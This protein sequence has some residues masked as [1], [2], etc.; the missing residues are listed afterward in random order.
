MIIIGSAIRG[1]IQSNNVCKAL[2]SWSFPRVG[3]FAAL[4]ADIFYARRVPAHGACS[5]YYFR[6]PGTSKMAASGSNFGISLR[7]Q[8]P[9]NARCWRPP[10]RD[11]AQ[12]ELTTSTR[13][14]YSQ[15]DWRLGSNTQHRSANA[16][17]L[18]ISDSSLIARSQAWWPI[19]FLECLLVFRPLKNN[20]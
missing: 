13:I 1:H 4:S 3:G 2:F 9:L 18:F 6:L 19:A 8:I 14:S 10:E 16:K 12:L 7:Q 17:L 5:A 20:M 11:R 15:R